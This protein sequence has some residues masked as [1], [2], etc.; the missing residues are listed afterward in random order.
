MERVP[1]LDLEELKDLVKHKDTISNSLG[2][3]IA[4][5]EQEIA[6]C[7]EVLSVFDPEYAK[8]L[9]NGFKKD[10]ERFSDDRTD[11]RSSS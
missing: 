4:N 6:D 8:R 11:R 2:Q 5:A 9:R 1:D 7:L 10:L 3:R